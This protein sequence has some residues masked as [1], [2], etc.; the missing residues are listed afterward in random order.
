MADISD[1]LGT[2]KLSGSYDASNPM[3]SFF[4]AFNFGTNLIDNWIDS[5]LKVQQSRLNMQLAAQRGRQV[6]QEMSINQQK[7]DQAAQL[8]PLQRQAEQQRVQQ[9]QFTL[10]STKQELD[11]D[12]KAYEQVGPLRDEIKSIDKD[13]PDFD[14]KIA[15]LEEKYPDA[16]T[17]KATASMVVPFINE[18]SQR[19]AA[20]S[21]FQLAQGQKDT[22]KGHI[23]NGYLPESFDP[24]QAVASGQAQQLIDSGNRQAAIQRYQKAMPYMD[25]AERVW[26]QNEITRITGGY[27]GENQRAPDQTMLTP[28]GQLNPDSD[29]RLGT[30]ERKYNLAPKPAGPTKDI[31]TKQ[32]DAQGNVISQTTIKGVQA[33][34]GDVSAAG[35]QPETVTTGTPSTDKIIASKAFQGVMSD[36]QTGKLKLPE[37]TVLNSPEGRAWLKGEYL[38]RA[39]NTGEQIPGTGEIPVP[40][41]PERAG[42]KKSGLSYNETS[43]NDYAMPA[44]A[45]EKMGI[46]PLVWSNVMSEEGPT[47]GLDG[48]HP[49]VFGLW[50][51]KGGIEG[52]AYRRV[53]A[54]GPRSPEAY[55]AVTDAWINQFLPQSQPWQLESPGM[56]EL[57]IAD[58]QH[59]G[60]QYARAIIDRMGGWDAINAMDPRQAIET[61]SELRKPLWPGNNRPFPDGATD[62]VTRER[63]WA[64]RHAL[65]EGRLAER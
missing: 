47:P 3:G 14:K 42:K 32:Y 59:R 21:K 10:D 25:P 65:G 13:D 35:K 56:Q 48:S 38:K 29:A 30:I 43:N 16:F 19:R 53:M 1:P 52:A 45:T 40:P 63:A 7:A 33:T 18:L 11:R 27:Q 15:A 20:S 49:S 54:A 9:S 46:S 61:Y 41:E 36:V 55:H 24:D 44:G 23:Q 12:N 58:S 37:G 60:G 28:K 8:F 57:V 22:L 51:D 26:A 50:G 4:T 31:V 62:R 2:P 39:A 6:D 64:L 5:N 34:P 17:S